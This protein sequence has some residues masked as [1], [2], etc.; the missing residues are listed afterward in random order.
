MFIR[1]V[2][3][4]ACGYT[5]P[6]MSIAMGIFG[7]VGLALASAFLFSVKSFASLGN[8]AILDQANRQALDQLTRE[9]RQAR[10]VTAFSTNSITIVNG[11]AVAVTY[12]FRPAAKQL[13]RTA[14]DGSTKVLLQDCNLITFRLFQRNP[15]GGTYDIYPAASGNWHQTVKVVQLAWRTSRTTLNGLVQSESVQTAR[16][17]IRKQKTV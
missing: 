4:S 12:L 16:I 10:Q 17:V 15:I 13:M 8:Y 11:D 6:E 5:L 2:T 14:S 7:L 1:P 9:I 3:K